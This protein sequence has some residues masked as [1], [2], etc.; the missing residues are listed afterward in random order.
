MFS[1]VRTGSPTK[2]S[3]TV[4]FSGGPLP[5]KS[6]RAAAEAVKRPGFRFESGQIAE[7]YGSGGQAIVV[8]TGAGSYCDWRQAAAALGRFAAQMGIKD[9]HVRETSLTATEATIV[10]ES[11]G[12]LSWDPVLFRGS[13]EK[14]RNAIPVSLQ[15]TDKAT[16][17]AFRTGLAIAEC[18]NFTRELVQTPPNVATPE[19]MAKEAQRVAKEHGLKA[20]VLSGEQLVKERMT[21]LIE[22]GKAS[23]HLPRF[24]RLEYCPK[25]REKDAPVVLLGKTVTYDTGGLSLKDRANMRGMKVDKAGG[26]AVLGAMIALAKVHR[27]DV[28]VVGILVAAEN[29]VSDEAYRPDDVLTF[30]NGVTVE[31][32]NTDAEGRL[33]LADGLCW[34]CEVEKARC[35]VDIATLTGGVVRALG[36]VYAGLFANDEKLCAAVQ[37]AGYATDEMLWRLPLHAR[38]QDMMRSPVADVQNSNMSG[39]AHPVQGATFLEFFVKRGTP[40]AHIDMAGHGTVERDAGPLVPG[41]TGFG[42]R[43]LSEFVKSLEPTS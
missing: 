33:V 8:G 34:A 17:R 38:Y 2:N 9:L 18:T 31:V 21:G 27:P 29:C 32:T 7:S 15:S 41:P 12:L 1:S 25:G 23:E 10:G 22:V 37:T 20:T 39:M 24:I 13:A 6:P 40:W 4:V 26:C 43:L 36:S 11:F 28:R 35:I 30:R 14:R 42:V 16:Q 3:V 5:Q 19:Y